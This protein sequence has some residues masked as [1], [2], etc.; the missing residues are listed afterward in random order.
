MAVLGI[1]A[2]TWYAVPHNLGGAIIAAVW[3]VA[4]TVILALGTHAPP[5]A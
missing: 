4:L 2:M 5:A 1:T 3:V